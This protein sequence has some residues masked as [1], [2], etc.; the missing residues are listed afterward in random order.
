LN[1]GIALGK[2]QKFRP[3]LSSL[4]I[5][6]DDY[7]CLEFITIVSSK[8]IVTEFYIHTISYKELNNQISELLKDYIAVTE[9]YKVRFFMYPNLYGSR[10]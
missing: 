8:S 9:K 6:Y 1:I 2:V 3:S 7:F 4:N 10:V 5:S